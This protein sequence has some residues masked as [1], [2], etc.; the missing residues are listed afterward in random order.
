MGIGRDARGGGGGAA[1]A[2]VSSSRRGRAPRGPPGTRASAGREAG[3]ER[4]TARSRGRSTKTADV[5]AR[6][7]ERTTILIAPRD[8]AG[9]RRARTL[10]ILLMLRDC[11]VSSTSGTTLFP[12][13]SSGPS[14]AP[15]LL[16]ELCR[17]TL[18]DP[19]GDDPSSAGVSC[20]LPGECPPIDAVRR[21]G[22]TLGG[23]RRPS[24]Q[25][26]AAADA[27]RSV[28]YRLPGSRPRGAMCGRSPDDG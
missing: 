20:P 4:R 3:S 16:R 8:R 22:M 15:R 11:A 6:G 21:I 7:V 25:N 10:M 9:E 24:V 19:A 13:A 5:A 12:R 2:K 17:L 18:L 26:R 27:M 23:A 28:R 1:S 14:A